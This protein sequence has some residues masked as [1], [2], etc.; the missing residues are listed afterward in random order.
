MYGK[1]DPKE[2]RRTVSRIYPLTTKLLTDG[3]RTAEGTIRRGE[4]VGYIISREDIGVVTFGFCGKGGD[5]FMS[6]A[7]GVSY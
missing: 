7:I 3:A 5:K 1:N 4:D 6:Q 2:K